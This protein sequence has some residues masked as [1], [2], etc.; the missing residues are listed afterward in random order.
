MSFQYSF[1][2]N[3]M[4]KGKGINVEKK[5]IGTYSSSRYFSPLGTLSDEQIAI[6]PQMQKLPLRPLNVSHASCIR[7]VA[8]FRIRSE[9]KVAHFFCRLQV[10]SEATATALAL[11]RFDLCE[12]HRCARAAELHKLPSCSAQGSESQAHC[13]SQCIACILALEVEQR[14]VETWQCRNCSFFFF[15]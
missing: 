14:K 11:T 7:F 6:V 15:K 8:F 2:I 9:Q 4:L 10:C 1:C 12:Q 5:K 13:F 3:F